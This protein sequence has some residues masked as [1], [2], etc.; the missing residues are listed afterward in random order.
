MEFSN[1]NIGYC[2]CGSFCTLSD[3][4]V[5]LQ[6]LV[7]LGANVTPI[8]SYS[9][10]KTDTKFGKAS[11]FIDSV[12]NITGKKIINTIETAEPIGPKNYLDIMVVSPCTGNTMAKLN[13]GIT[14]T[15]VLM[16]IKAHLRNNKPVLIALATNDA[17]GA[18]LANIGGLINKKNFYFVPFSQDNFLKKPKS[19]ISNFDKLTS[20]IE[21]AIAGI[22]LQPIIESPK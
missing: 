7:D 1:L 5:Q 18:N 12:E 17:L 9:V 2:M 10:F 4:L 8:M 22:Q 6:K 3:S 21:L 15:P 13:H 19:M 16:A 11:F 20:A 14:D